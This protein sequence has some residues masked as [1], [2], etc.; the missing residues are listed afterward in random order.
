[1]KPN[2]FLIALFTGVACVLGA[3]AQLS[4]DN[5]D[6]PGAVGAYQTP[7]D[8]GGTSSPNSLTAV[9]NGVYVSMAQQVNLYALPHSTN[10]PPTCTF[11]TNF[12]KGM[13]VDTVGRLW[14]TNTGSR[15]VTTYRKG[16]CHRTKLTLNEPNGVPFDVAISRNG[17]VYVAD[18]VDSAGNHGVVSVYK[19]GTTTPSSTLTDE[20]MTTARAI[21]VD[22]S[23]NVFVSCVRERRNACIIEFANGQMPGKYLDVQVGI[24]AGLEID[25]QQNLLVDDPGA[26][27]IKSF[28]P[29]YQGVRTTAFPLRGSSDFG[30][31][32]AANKNFYASNFSQGRVDVFSY[33]SGAYEYS[34]T[35][36]L[37]QPNAVIGIA[38]DPASK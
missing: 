13:A 15:Q 22:R 20:K 35:N 17:T 3:H 21:A 29:P 16:T 34:I 8:L 26:R 12:S 30:K 9:A 5:S 33:P 7:D 31:L 1:M 2:L 18:I 19:K 10:L 6:S 32:D 25:T 36:G 28:A 14:V 4:Y 23:G 37:V 27:E 38:V 24:A 11:A